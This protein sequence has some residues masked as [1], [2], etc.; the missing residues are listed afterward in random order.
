MSKVRLFDD[1]LQTPN[2]E[3]IKGLKATWKRKGCVYSQ[4]PFCPSH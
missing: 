1:R 3:I 2:K 4:E